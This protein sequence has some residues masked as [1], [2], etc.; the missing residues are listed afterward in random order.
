LITA[1]VSKRSHDR[2][3]TYLSR[4]AGSFFAGKQTPAMEVRFDATVFAVGQ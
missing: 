3:S 4:E 1:V 2:R